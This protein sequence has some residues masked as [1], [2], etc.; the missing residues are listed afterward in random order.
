MSKRWRDDTRRKIKTIYWPVCALRVS[1]GKMEKEKETKAYRIVHITAHTF[2]LTHAHKPGFKTIDNMWN[3]FCTQSNGKQL[4]C[5]TQISW[6][7]VDVVVVFVCVH[8]LFCCAFIHVVFM[9][10]VLLFFYMV[11]R[12][13]VFNFKYCVTV[14]MYV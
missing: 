6:F 5:F 1:N 3:T 10:L 9:L 13:A 2:T 4:F 11:H 14:F 8:F 7:F 12:I